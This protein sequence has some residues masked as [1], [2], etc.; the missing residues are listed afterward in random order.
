MSKNATPIQLNDVQN[1]LNSTT[2]WNNSDF[3][4]IEYFSL[5]GEIKFDIKES[6]NLSMSL[7]Q[8][9]II[10]REEVVY[11]IVVDQRYLLKIGS[12][13]TN[14]DKRLKSYNCGQSKYRD[15]GTCSTTN[16]YVLQSLFN[17]A[18]KG[19]KVEIYTFLTSPIKIQ[20]DLRGLVWQLGYSPAK[21]IEKSILT[22]LKSNRKLPLM[23]T[24]T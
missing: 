9:N 22:S 17:I 11:A 15:N 13:T 14:F 4:D 7:I 20:M 24:Q 5:L 3:P 2:A 16:Y 18:A 19:H 1:A 8:S 12:A 10:D 6:G 21:N 23:C